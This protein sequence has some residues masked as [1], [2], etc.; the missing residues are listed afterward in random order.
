MLKEIKTITHHYFIDENGHIQG[1]FKVYHDNE[2][3]Y[4][5]SFYQNGKLH[6]YYKRHDVN[7][8]LVYATF[9]YQNN[10]LNVNPDT[11]TEQDKTY[12]FLSGRL[13]PRD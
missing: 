11:L 2:Q 13:P 7:G 12:I 1:E 8:K 3:L 5:Q 4:I 6:S 9:F 10:D